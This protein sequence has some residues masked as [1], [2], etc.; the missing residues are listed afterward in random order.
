[1]STLPPR[2]LNRSYP[3]NGP[4][5]RERIYIGRGSVYGNPFRIGVD[6]TREQVIQKY[7]ERLMNDPNLLNM[8]RE[9]LRGRDLI[10]FCAPLPCHGDI[11]LRVANQETFMGDFK[12]LGKDPNVDL[13]AKDCPECVQG[14]HGNCDG[15]ADLTDEDGLVPCVCA[16]SSHKE[17]R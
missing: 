11:L 12:L 7:E 16:L 17:R 6:G 14:K 4:A 8:V 2:V 10:C 15:V 13:Y 5:D 1:M 9:N 3:D